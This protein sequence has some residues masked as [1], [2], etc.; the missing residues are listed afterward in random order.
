MVCEDALT[1]VHRR[2]DG[3]PYPLDNTDLLEEKLLP[4]FEEYQNKKNANVSSAGG[5]TLETAAKRQEWYVAA[6]KLHRS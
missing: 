4:K 2:N 3:W 1:W 6:P 5:C